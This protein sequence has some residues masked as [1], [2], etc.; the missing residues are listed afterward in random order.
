MAVARNPVPVATPDP[1]AHRIPRKR[2]T[3]TD[4]SFERLREAGIRHVQALSGHT[5]TDYNLHDPGV[6]IL[7]QLCYALTDL[8]YRTGFPVADHL[9][10]PDGRIDFAGLA[11]H[12]PAA[13]FPCRPSTIADYRRALLDT[14]GALD[15]VWLDAERDPRTGIDGLFRIAVKHAD[16]ADDEGDDRVVRERDRAA[17][18][19][20]KEVY[21]SNRN[22]C[23]DVGQVV[24]VAKVDCDLFGEFEIGGARDPSDV[25]ADILDE[26]ARAVASGVVFRSFEWAT[27]QGQL[28]EQILN[29]LHTRHG[30]L[31][32]ADLDQADREDLFVG[33]LASRVRAI[34]GVRMVR[35]LALGRAG[36]PPTTGTLRWDQRREALRVRFPPGDSL[37]D[38][39]RVTRAGSGVRLDPEEVRAKYLDRRAA[40]RTRSQARQDISEAWPPPRGVHREF[41]RYTSIQNQFPAI[42]GIN[43]HGL[44][45]SASAERKAQAR[46]LKA[47]LMLFEQIIANGG[48]Q[49]HHVRDLFST[50]ADLG[51]TYW[52]HVLDPET[53]PD[54]DALYTGAAAPDRLG[55]LVQAPLDPFHERRHR[56][57]DHL[58]A[59]HGETLAQNTL[60]HWMRYHDAA[61]VEDALLANKLRFL[62]NVVRLGRDRASGFDYGRPTWNEPG[63]G[64]PNCSGFQ[65]RVS[66][67]LGFRH[68]HSRP[69]T[70]AI[71]ES[72]L[73]VD[74]ADDPHAGTG[75]PD[76]TLT[77]SP[78][79]DRAFANVVPHAGGDAVDIREIRRTHR[80]FIGRGDRVSESL[81]HYGTDLSRYRVGRLAG[82]DESLLL[83]RPEG[84]A[85]WWVLGYAGT[86]DP[87]H[88]AANRLR[89]FLIELD[90]E[91]EGMHVVEHVL[92]RPTIPPG[93]DARRALPPPDFNSLRMSVLFP[94]W[95]A[96]C[97]EDGFR[98]FAESTVRLNCPAHVHAECLWLDYPAMS[99]FE[100]LYQ[101]WLTARIVVCRHPEDDPAYAGAART[102]DGES[103]AVAAFLL[104]HGVARTLAENGDE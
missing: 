23:E 78:S 7:E 55:A 15:N 34:D 27:D 69:L 31:E 91:S 45:E 4:T 49:L 101:R 75:E 102:L 16:R 89:R 42:Y 9:T 10:R 66:C 11:L 74:P 98:R 63:D 40:D 94:A 29:P 70:A 59:L 51:Q 103:R 6:T 85:R 28:P 67:L 50:R 54:V 73:T 47:Y 12:G 30:V 43:A 99:A 38:T 57:L 96:R 39:L 76:V 3:A 71:R 52:W 97:H 36:A 88:E 95:T 100:E 93:P 83:F 21:R 44:P 14:V 26:C 13:V 104:R 41:D 2:G 84:G 22:L 56:V 32:D 58:L 18:E 48:A 62:D 24:S 60:R 37:R 79:R 80:L 72:G 68:L 33:D 20:V 82:R 77:V 8:I 17:R 64:T 53:V 1:A 5:W 87:V 65:M 46:Q 81:L 25:V 61:D 86:P 90:V 35:Y 92:L 19:R